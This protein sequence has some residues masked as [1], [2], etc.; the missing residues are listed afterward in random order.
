M[1]LKE[2]LEK[3]ILNRRTVTLQNPDKQLSIRQ[4]LIEAPLS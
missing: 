2:W 1:G 3:N 4:I